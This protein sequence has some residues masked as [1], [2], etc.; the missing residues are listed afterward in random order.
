VYEA[1]LEELLADGALTAKERRTLLR[2][3]REL[4][5][6]AAMAVRVEERVLDR[7]EAT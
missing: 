3:Q 6:D 5:L 7:L 4:Q 2:L 1:A